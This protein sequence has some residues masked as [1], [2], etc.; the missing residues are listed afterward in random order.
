MDTLRKLFDLSGR[1]ALIFDT[2]LSMLQHIKAER[3]RPLAVTTPARASILPNLPTISEAGVPGYALTLWIAIYAP[4]GTPSPIVARLN[5]EIQHA[6]NL[7]EVREQMT[8]QGAEIARPGNAGR[9]GRERQEQQR[10]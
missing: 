4:A 1:V 2:A 3:V 5:K 9:N 10:S 7:P 6:L 8:L